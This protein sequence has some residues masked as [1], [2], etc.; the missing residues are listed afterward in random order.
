MK[1]SNFE[2]GLIFIII[3]QFAFNVSRGTI[4]NTCLVLFALAITHYIYKNR[5]DIYEW[6]W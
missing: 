4:A 2:L 3:G 5:G 6:N 1:A